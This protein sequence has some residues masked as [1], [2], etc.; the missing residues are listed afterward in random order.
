MHSNRVPQH[1]LQS[2]ALGSL[3]RP[4]LLLHGLWRSHRRLRRRL[5][6]TGYMELGG[7]R[8]TPAVA[9]GVSRVGAAFA[10]AMNA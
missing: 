3:S 7:K 9:G 6:L 8:Y 1:E 10:V 4:R 2:N 5:R